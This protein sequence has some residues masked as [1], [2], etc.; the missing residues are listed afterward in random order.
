MWLP[1]VSAAVRYTEIILSIGLFSLGKSGY[2]LRDHLIEKLLG[3]SS[4]LET[5]HCGSFFDESQD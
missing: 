4:W 3:S 5:K 2:V 1:Y